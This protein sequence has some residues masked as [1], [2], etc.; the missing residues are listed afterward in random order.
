MMGIS[1]QHTAVPLGKILSSTL[2]FT[3]SFQKSSLNYLYAKNNNHPLEKGLEDNEKNVNVTVLSVE[4][5]AFYLSSISK[6][7]KNRQCVHFNI[8]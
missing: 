7:K 6:F 4:I 2:R 8:I 1:P 3:S 5:L